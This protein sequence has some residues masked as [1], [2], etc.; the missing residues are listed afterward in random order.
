MLKTGGII[1]FHRAL[2]RWKYLFPSIY[3]QYLSDWGMI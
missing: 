2:A 1:E 3:E